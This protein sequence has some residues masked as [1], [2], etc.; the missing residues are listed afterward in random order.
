M[1]QAHQKYTKGRRMRTQDEIVARIKERGKEDL[2]GFE[3]N[4]LKL[5]LDYE[6]VKSYLKEGVTDWEPRVYFA[7]VMLSYME[8]AWGKANNCRGISACRSI[9]HY[10]AW[11]WLAEEDDLLA[12]VDKE[13]ESNYQHYGKE[14]LV[15]ICDHFG[16]DWKQYDN[17]RWVNSEDE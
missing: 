9:M 14:I 2:C 1:G 11:L 13:F 3:V 16:W 6:H 15:H 4:E 10:Q 8:F 7:Q 5:F 17:G 12:W